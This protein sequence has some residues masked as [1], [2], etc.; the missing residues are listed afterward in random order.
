MKANVVCT[1]S[2]LYYAT[3]LG[4]HMERHESPLFYCVEDFREPLKS[5][6]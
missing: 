4:V 2:P 1:D 5:Q 3:E 6:A